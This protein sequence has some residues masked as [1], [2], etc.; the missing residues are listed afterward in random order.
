MGLTYH[1]KF[2]ASPQTGAAELVSF[3]QEVE[4]DAQ[5]L[6]L[7]P[8]VV[9]DAPFDSKERLLFARRFT[10]GLFVEDPRLIGARLSEHNTIWSFDPVGGSCR[11]APERGVVLVVTDERGMEMVFGF[12]RYPPSIRDEAGRVIMPAPDP[13]AWVFSDFIKSAD[14][15]YRR[16]VRRFAERSYLV[17]EADDYTTLVAPPFEN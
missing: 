13:S 8:T 11:L 4:A 14:A 3:L 12:M 7:S 2:R 5:K 15:R 10:T 9:V 6:G 16:I 1:Y 17:T